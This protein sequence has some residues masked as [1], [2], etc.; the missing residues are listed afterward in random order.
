MVP[1]TQWKRLEGVILGVDAP[2][3]NGPYPS[4]Q[5]RYSFVAAYVLGGEGVIS[6]PTMRKPRREYPDDEMLAE[7]CAPGDPVTVTISPD[8]DVQL[9]V[10]TEAWAVEDC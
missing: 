1:V 4:G 9:F 2:S 3:G 10:S 6:D 7:I 5:V 8:N